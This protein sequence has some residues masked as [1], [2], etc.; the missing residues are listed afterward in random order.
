MWICNKKISYRTPPFSSYLGNWSLLTGSYFINHLYV[1]WIRSAL[2]GWKYH[3]PMLREITSWYLAFTLNA[4]FFFFLKDF[5][6]L[7]LSHISAICHSP[8]WGMQQPKWHC[9]NVL[10]CSGCR[11]WCPDR[12]VSE[13]TL[14]LGECVPD[15]EHLSGPPCWVWSARH[16][17]RATPANPHA[18]LART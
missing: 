15:W 17:L 13:Q 10:L 14:L 6:F 11:H 12:G 7:S 8:W 1:I 4:T 5:C 18:Q 16:L 2:K 3:I 9:E